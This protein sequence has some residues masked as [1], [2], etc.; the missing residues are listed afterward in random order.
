MIA[1]LEDGHAGGSRGVCAHALPERLVRA[2]S[3]QCPSQCGDGVYEEKW[4]ADAS[5]DRRTYG[6]LKQQA[7]LT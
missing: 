5:E 4:T 2:P 1:N 6:K 3:N 7:F